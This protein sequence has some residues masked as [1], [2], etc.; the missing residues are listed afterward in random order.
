MIVSATLISTQTTA[1]QRCISPLPQETLLPVAPESPPVQTPMGGFLESNVAA[2][3]NAEHFLN[4]GF[5]L[6]QKVFRRSTTQN[7]TC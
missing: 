6:Q 3:V 5:R 1:S 7:K 2:F 4:L